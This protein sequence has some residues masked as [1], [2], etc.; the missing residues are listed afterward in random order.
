MKPTRWKYTR[1][2][3]AAIGLGGLLLGAPGVGADEPPTGP[4]LGRV[5]FNIGMDIP[6]RYYFRG[7]LQEEN[8]LIAQPYF[9]ANV[10]LYEG[11]QLTATAIGGIW[12]SI[13]S[14][15]TGS[16]L[17]QPKA[18][19]E[20]DAY[21]GMALGWEN[22][23]FSGIWTTYLS[24]SGAFSEVNDIA[25]GIGYDDSGHLGA[26]ALNPAITFI[27]ET[28]GTAFGVNK[29]DLLQLSAGPEFEITEGDRPVTL[30]VPV[31]L[32]LSLDDYYERTDTS[33]PSGKNDETFGYFQTGL[34]FGFPMAFVPNEY[35]SWLLNAGFRFISLGKSLREVNH[36]GN[37]YGFFGMFG[38]SMTY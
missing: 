18:W 5:S 16:S 20:F 37:D 23:E 25:L 14:E 9:E 36:N 15:H 26:F 10:N 1:A 11:E 8:G 13:H 22:L 27:L 33:D 17:D 12:N 32:G 31:E 30:G 24:P 19:Y 2:L 4:N 6:T 3:A 38:V 7:I 29:G 21:G 34:D 28:K 35:G